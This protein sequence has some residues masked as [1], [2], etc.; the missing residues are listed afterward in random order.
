[1][2]GFD[3]GSV[4]YA[5]NVDFTGNSLTG[6]TAQITTNGQLL[7]G[8]TSVPNIKVGTLTSPNG[9]IAIGYS[10]PNI[11]LDVSGTT[12]LETLTGNSG[13][14]ISPT[15][16]NINTLGSGSITIVGAGS[17]LTTQL[18]GLTSHNVLI[19]A[20]TATITKVAPSATSGVPLISQGAAADPAFGT[21]VVAGGGTGDTS[22]TAFAPVCGGTTTTGA[23]QSAD[24]GIGTSG[25]VLT[26]TGA[27]S[28]PTFQAVPSTGITTIDGN[29]G[30]V[31][32]STVTIEN[33]ANDGTPFFTGS[34]STMTMFF[35][36]GAANYNMG[37]GFQSLGFSSPSG[38]G[39]VGIGPFSQQS[40]SSGIQNT[41]LGQQALLNLTSGNQNIGIGYFTLPNMTTGSGNIALNINAFPGTAFTNE[42]YNVFIQHTGLAG[43]N[44]TLRIGGATGSGAFQLNQAFI[45]GINGITVTGT[46]VLVSASDQLGVAA[47]SGKLKENLSPASDISSDIYKL[48]PVSFNYI[49]DPDKIPCLGMIAEEVEKVYP[50]L[51]V[52]DREM[53]PLSLKYQE[54]PML[55]LAEIQKLRKEVDE[56]KSRLGL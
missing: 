53:Q 20:G 49:S 1:M 30:S 7:I 33:A 26:S 21:A 13:G 2:P 54:L 52:Y 22:F 23:L 3:T 14:P 19:G 51:V 40:N 24:T 9:T 8:S 55:L 31:T 29:S 12:V 42:S 32:G 25:F 6:G 36:T 46:A 5:L 16:G 56:L 34:G 48:N 17:T 4:M 35:D 44:N 37:L 43:D 47:S 28:L 27:G 11:T 50:R 10:A 18:T 39:N 38:A 45:A 41:S 15:A